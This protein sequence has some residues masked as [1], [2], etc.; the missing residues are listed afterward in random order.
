VQY[1]ALFGK[2]Y[3]DFYTVSTNLC[4]ILLFVVSNMLYIIGKIPIMS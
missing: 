2:I 3:A 4:S 1:I